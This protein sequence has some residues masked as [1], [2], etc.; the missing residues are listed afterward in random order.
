MGGVLSACFAVTVPTSIS[1][2][3]APALTPSPHP[4]IHPCTAELLLQST[5]CGP[6]CMH[7]VQVVVS[8][9]AAPFLHPAVVEGERARNPLPQ[10]RFIS[11][12][13]WG[14]QGAGQEKT[15]L[16]LPI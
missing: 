9:G 7:H 4:K 6:W 1:L 11:L 10:G 12:L 8:R 16:R 14:E 13:L 5:N 2:A 3:D 15:R